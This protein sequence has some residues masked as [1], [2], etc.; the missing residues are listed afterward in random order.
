LRQAIFSK[1]N[2]IN[3][4]KASTIASYE[5][6]EI[7]TTKK[8]MPFEDGNVIKQRVVAAGESLLN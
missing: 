3:K 7:L 1:S 4:A 8:M 2:P 5:N 6:T